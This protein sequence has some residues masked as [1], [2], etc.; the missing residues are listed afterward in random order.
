MN[1]EF[2]PD[3]TQTV[4]GPTATITDAVQVLNDASLRLVLVL[5][6]QKKIL[7]TVTDGDIRRGLIRQLGMSTPIS[8]IMNRTPVTVNSHMGRT[9]MIQLMREKDIF[10]LPVVRSDGTVVGVEFLQSLT[11]Q[12]TVQNVAVLMAGGFGKRLQPLTETTPK[13]ML[14]VG[15]K[16]I[17]EIIVEQLAD[18]GFRKI[19]ISVFYKAGLVQEYFGRGEKWGV[20]IDYLVEESPLGTAGALSLL[21]GDIGTNPVLVMN[22]DILTRVDFSKLIQFH[23]EQQ[24]RLTVGVR[25]Y[26]FQVPYGVIS[27]KENRILQVTEKPIHTFFVNAGIYVMDHALID[28]GNRHSRCD[29]TEVIEKQLSANQSVNAFPIHEYW[30]DI[31]MIEQ[32]EQANWDVRHEEND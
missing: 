3:W 23:E 31:G 18:S 8:A 2:R 30:I 5:D 4:L 15:S 22:G 26:D 32:Y 11:V 16:P 25:E 21:P 24:C 29:M 12:P 27:I 13:P 17:L 1:S 28:R 6:Q 10:Q 7:G 14:K 9:S 20:E 19:F